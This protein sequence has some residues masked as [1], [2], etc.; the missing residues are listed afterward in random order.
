MLEG[1]WQAG[2]GDRCPK[3]CIAHPKVLIHL[4]WHNFIHSGFA[5]E[6]K[7]WPATGIT[8]YKKIVRGKCWIPVGFINVGPKKQLVKYGNELGIN[9][10]IHLE[11]KLYFRLFFR[12]SDTIWQHPNQIRSKSE[13]PIAQ[14][15]DQWAN[16]LPGLWEEEMQNVFPLSGCQDVEESFSNSECDWLRGKRNWNAAKFGGGMIWNGGSWIDSDK[17]GKFSLRFASHFPQSQKASF[18]SY[19]LFD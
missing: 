13:C 16:H 14:T 2:P 9:I 18:P 17:K 3:E 8:N 12:F 15:N 10:H 11:D 1:V 6:L 4:P 7:V 5:V 19:S